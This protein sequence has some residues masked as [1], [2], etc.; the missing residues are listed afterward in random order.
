MVQEVGHVES[1]DYQEDGTYIQARVTEALA[2]RLR[3][4]YV[5]GDDEETINSSTNTHSSDE[6]EIDW[7]AIGRGRHVKKNHDDEL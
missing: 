5:S 4:F 2:N 6:E 1:I 7:V 3:P